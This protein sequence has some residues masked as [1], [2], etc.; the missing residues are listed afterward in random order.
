M[1]KKL[2][3]A[4][5]AIA[6]LCASSCKKMNENSAPMPLNQGEPVLCSFSVAGLDVPTPKSTG[7]ESDATG[8]AAEKT[9]NT[10][11]VFVFTADNNLV[12]SGIA[13]NSKNITLSVNAGTNYSMYAI[14]NAEDWTASVAKVSDLEAKVTEA[15]GAANANTNFAM[16]GKITGQTVSSTSKSFAI[17][18]ERVAA[19]VVLRKVTNSLPAAIGTLTIEGIYLSNV[20]TTSYMF[21]AT[22]AALPSGAKWVNQRGIY[23]ALSSYAWFGDKLETAAVVA[24]GGNYGTAHTFYAAANPTAEDSSAETFGPRFTRLVVKAKVQGVTYY[25]PVSFN[26]DLPALTPNSYID[27]TNLTIKHLGSTDPDQPIETDD[28]TITVTVKDWSKTE[29]EVTL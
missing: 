22:P 18:V 14:A 1:K 2:F 25:Y 17:D 4:I 24:N 27:I 15:L 23:D 6:V 20:V 11:Q 12:A 29:Q 10:L 26:K 13:S 8:I 5:A 19:K 21:P 9:V 7:L 28:I 3:F 16:Q